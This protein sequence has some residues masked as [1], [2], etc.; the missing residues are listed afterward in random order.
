VIGA[1]AMRFRVMTE[2]QEGASYDDLVAVARLAEEVGFD[3]FFRSDH[4]VGFG[5]GNHLPGPTD[6]WTT[7]AGLARETSTVRLGTLVSPV[8]FR[9]PGQLALVVAQVDAMS[10]GRVELGVGAGWNEAEHEAHAIPYPA[11]GERFGRLE[12]QLAILRGFWTTPAGERFSFAGRH[13]R[14][15]DSPALPKPVQQPHPPVVVGG[16]GAP[17]SARLAA[18]YADEYNVPMVPPDVFRETND[19]VDAAC[20]ASGRDPSTLRRSVM[21]TTI[22]GTDE[23][24]VARRVA[25]IGG[26]FDELQGGRAVGTPAQVVDTLGTYREAGAESVYFQLLDLHDPDHLRL[27]AAEVLPAMS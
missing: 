27:L 21:L 6:A 20:E 23:A 7:L 14:V 3:G 18:T 5:P 15:A 1:R 22:C 12:E 9:F 17:R 13:Y 19:R 25:A 10:G 8:T 24:D 16:F 2:P 11:L 4:Y 26:A